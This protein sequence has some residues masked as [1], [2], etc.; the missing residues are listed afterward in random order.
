M[1]SAEGRRR[2]QHVVRASAKRRITL[3]NQLGMLLSRVS[4]GGL[5]RRPQVWAA[6]MIGGAVALVIL[7]VRM[8]V[9]T[10]V[11]MGDNGDGFRLLCNVGLGNVRP[12]TAP[13]ALAIYP[14]WESTSWS[15]LACPGADTAP[16]SAYYLLVAVGRLLSLPFGGGLDLRVL[17]MLLALVVAA[18]VVALIRYLPGSTPFRLTVSAAMLLV[19]MD[20]SFIDLFIAADDGGVTLLA[21]LAA[22]VALLI[23]W[24]GYAE[25]VTTLDVPPRGVVAVTLAV[26]IAAAVVSIGPVGLAFLPGFIAGLLWVPRLRDAERARSRTLGR[27]LPGDRRREFARKLSRRVPAI[28][29][30]A[31]LL[32]I[33]AAQVGFAATRD[34][35]DDLYSTIFLTIL[36]V[37]P[38]PQAD[39]EWFGLQASLESAIGQ[40][41]TSVEASAALADP[42]FAAVGPSQIV[43]FHLSHLERIVMLADRGM[44]ALA[45]PLLADRGNFL[46]ERLDDEGVIEHD[47]RWIPVQ[48]GSQLLYSIPLLI[49]ASQIA[50]I[51]LAL[52]LAFAHGSSV[53]SRSLGWATFFLFIGSALVFWAALLG[54]HTSLAE[55]LLPST[56]VLWLAG[57]LMLACA[58]IR[59]SAGG[60]GSKSG[61][62]EP[63]PKN[64]RM[65]DTTRDAAWPSP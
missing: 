61:S 11:G 63:T 49:P 23:L 32:G 7:L 4:P 43:L 2:A 31:L 44:A 9:P 1:S 65:A 48:W 33:A 3:T 53:R 30:C 34:R 8:F 46:A 24:G 51:L 41:V 47:R 14:G 38:T 64:S 50:G 56:L 54:D 39:L 20:S 37:S 29:A 17:G 26:V 52:A 27:A 42:A 59:L 62:R 60:S 21:V 10:V 19:V 40:P 28:L 12:F 6:A 15:G 36:P 25:R 13:P 16:F 55:V 35:H 22:F 58:A 5:E 45:S 57:P 18:L